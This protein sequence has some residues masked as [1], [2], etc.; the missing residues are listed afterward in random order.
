MSE[1]S[2]AQLIESLK[3][4]AIEVAE[5]ESAMILDQARIKARQLVEQAEE[6]QDSLI[7]EAKKEVQAILTNG[8]SALRQA[9]R[10]FSISVRNELI[11]VFQ[12]VLQD[13]IRREFTPDLLKHAILKIIEHTGTDVELRLPQELS[14]ELSAY[15]HTRL[16]ASDKY[17]TLLEKSSLVKGFSVTKSDQGWSYH[18]TPEEVATA[19]SHHLNPNWRHLLKKDK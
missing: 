13:E 11:K 14:E 1:K 9:S 3:S 16:N 2:L 4:E 19:L 5:K 7:T 10:D 8:E 17:V 12:A 15:I 18:V 6:K